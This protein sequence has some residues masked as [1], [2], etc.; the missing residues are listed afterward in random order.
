MP[1][2]RRQL[3]AIDEMVV[4]IPAAVQHQ[5]IVI[6]ME[7]G[8]RITRRS[9]LPNSMYSQMPYR[10]SRARAVPDTTNATR[11]A[12]MAVCLVLIGFNSR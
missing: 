2:Y 9:A 11:P 4:M 6:M 8:H 10:K 3:I 5:P 1:M 7:D 12:M